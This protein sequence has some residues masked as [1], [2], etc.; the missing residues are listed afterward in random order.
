VNPVAIAS[1]G[2]FNIV[3]ESRQRKAIDGVGDYERN[4]EELFS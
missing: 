2:V 1:K 3:E 4:T